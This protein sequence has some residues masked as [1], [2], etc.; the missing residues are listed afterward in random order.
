[1]KKINL[2]NEKKRDALLGFEA[3]PTRQKV[4]QVLKDGSQKRNVKVL[5]STLETDVAELEKKYSDLEAVAQA[6]ITD[7]IEVDLEH[8]GMLVDS[9]SKIYADKDGSIVFNVEMTEVLKDKEGNE[10]ARR[11]LEQ[12]QANISLDGLPVKW[13]GKLFPK[14]EA[15]KKFIFSKHYQVRHVNG[16]TFDFLYDMAKEL[17]EKDSLMFVG[18]GE[19]GNEPL[20]LSTGG[21]PYRAFLEGRVDGDKYCLILHLTNL[22]LKEFAK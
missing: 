21:T 4:F 11:P 18:G 20:V 14:K 12:K 3:K 8:T 17:H 15:V 19:K 9:V 5:K 7:D 10:T 16:L 6:M 22:E 1:M 2:A 13:S